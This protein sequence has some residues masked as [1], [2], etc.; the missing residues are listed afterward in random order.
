MKC[1]VCEEEI[2]SESPCYRIQIGAFDGEGKFDVESLTGYVHEG[3]LDLPE[4]G[5]EDEKI[6]TE[7]P[8]EEDPEE[9][10]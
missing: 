7:N 3:C 10:E 4:A 2:E 1:H 9:G 5:F 6:D 8:E